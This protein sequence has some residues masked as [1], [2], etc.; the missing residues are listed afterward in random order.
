MP[1]LPWWKKGIIYQIYPRSFQD[2]N[3]DGV[4][5]L[6]GIIRRLDY[7]QWL[8]VDAIWLSPIFPSPMVDFGY[9][10][11]DYVGVDPLFGTLD[12]FDRLVAEANEKGIRVIL[13]FV[14]NHTS[15]H[16][17]WFKQSR[18][19]RSNPKRDWYI[20][21]DGRDNGVPPNNWLSEFGGS[22]WEYDSTTDQYYLHSFFKQQP[23][24]NWRNPEVVS[25]IFDGLRFW[26]DR[27]VAGFRFDVIDLLLKDSLLRDDPPNPDYDEDDFHWPWRSLIHAHSGYQTEVHEIIRGIRKLI[28]EYEDRVIIGELDYFLG[29]EEIS[30]FYGENDQLHLPFNFGL[31]NISWEM[32]QIREFVDQYDQSVPEFAWPVYVLSNHDRSRVASRIGSLQ[33]RCAAMLLLTLRGT[34]F[35]YYGEE[36]GM[37]DVPIQPNQVQDSW[38]HNVPGLGRDP[39]RTPM[40]WNDAPNAGF[41]SDNPWL[42][43]GHNYRYDNVQTQRTDDTSFL[44]LYHKLIHLRRETPALFVGNYRAIDT[45]SEDV[46]GYVRQHEDDV[47]FIMINFG[48]ETVQPSIDAGTQGILLLS[49]YLDRSPV[50]ELSEVI[51]RANEGCIFRVSQHLKAIIKNRD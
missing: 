18:S 27:G 8:G 10:V 50:T 40:C 11:A 24:L 48:E 44:N 2:S 14:P 23:D 21:R 51:L 19:S 25:A 12:D 42:P 28:D 47:L 3:G 35:I 1:I 9:D 29:N 38:E 22:A 26:L 33:A 37:L 13:D 30:Q 41:T 6:A 43:L 15:D 31:F 34:P 17:E 4:G 49:T 39:A 7:L 36:L 5:D 46:M 32:K 16:H 20:W 45:G